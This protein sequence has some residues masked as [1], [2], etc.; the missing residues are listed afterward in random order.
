MLVTNSDE[1]VMLKKMFYIKFL[2]K[3]QESQKWI[4]ALHDSNSKIN[5]MNPNYA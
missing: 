1:K 5:A 3:F 4:K 2:I